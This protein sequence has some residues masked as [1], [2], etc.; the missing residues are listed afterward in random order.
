MTKNNDGIN[1]INETIAE[2]HFK[3][4]KKLGEGM[5]RQSN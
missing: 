1:S 2:I 4:N 3:I 5:F